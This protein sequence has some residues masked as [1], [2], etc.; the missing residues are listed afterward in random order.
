[1]P[2]I[3][4][5]TVESLEGLI[6]A[7]IKLEVKLRMDALGAKLGKD[8][9]LHYEIQAYLGPT[10]SDSRERI[11]KIA[12][13]KIEGVASADLAARVTKSVEAAILEVF[14][15]GIDNTLRIY[16]K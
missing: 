13:E 2:N 5:S 1:M 14:H 15:K 9:P 8:Y 16:M 12:L 11:A 3:V 7:Q 4:H 6:T 10:Q